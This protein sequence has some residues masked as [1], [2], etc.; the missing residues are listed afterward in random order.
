MPDP[1]PGATAA[2]PVAAEQPTAT[3]PEG[4]AAPATPAPV[5]TV[6]SRDHVVTDQATGEKHNLGELIEA[7]KNALSPEDQKRF[8]T[9]QRSMAGD[10]DATRELMEAA[11]PKPVPKPEEQVG[12]LQQQYDDLQK[13]VT[14]LQEQ[15][16]GTSAVTDQVRTIADLNATG[17]LVEAGVKEYPMLHR[18]V[19]HSGVG[20][21]QSVHA[22][23][24]QIVQAVQQQNG[25]NLPFGSFPPETQV[26]INKAALA[27]AESNLASL[28][29]VYGLKPEAAPTAPQVTSINDQGAAPSAGHQPARMSVNQFNQTVVDGQV[30]GASPEAPNPPLPAVPVTP[31]SAGAAPGPVPVQDPNRPM[32]L[33]EMNANL[34]A[35]GQQ[36]NALA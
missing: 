21:L 6:V 20:V 24:A 12:T 25:T 27:Q 30:V 17:R 11:I 33:D 36:M 28:M 32:T 26:V 1:V 34:K 31:P 29:G 8:E 9:Y 18:L 15:V 16:K 3:P 4:T 35:R 7:K 14:S 22:A 2:E 5:D 19:A 13:T 23:R 10:I